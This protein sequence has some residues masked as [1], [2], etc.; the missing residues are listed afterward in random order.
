LESNLCVLHV[1]IIDFNMSAR[2]IIDYDTLLRSLE[3]VLLSSLHIAVH[4]LFV[5]SMHSVS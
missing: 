1:L 4:K 3:V 2:I 5:S